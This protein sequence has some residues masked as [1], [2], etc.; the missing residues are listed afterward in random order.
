VT[1]GPGGDVSLRSFRDGISEIDAFGTMLSLRTSYEQRHYLRNTLAAVAASVL[2]GHTPCGRIEPVFSPLRG[3]VVELPAGVRL[4]N[5]CYNAN[6][7]SVAAAL[8]YLAGFPANRR[9]AVLGG[10]GELGDESARYHFEIGRL[11]AKLPID[12]LILVGPGTPKIAEGFAA[13]SHWVAN[14]PEAADVLRR[15]MRA[16]DVILVKGEHILGLAQIA[17]ELAER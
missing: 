1:F 11:A 15:S 10:M 13:S 3:E 2:L 14:A 4:I 8:E 12:R 7:A 5:D 16:G 6:P 17:A 9:I